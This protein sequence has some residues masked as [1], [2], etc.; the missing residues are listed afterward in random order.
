MSDI[1]IFPLHSQLALWIKN[2]N[3]FQQNG[4]RQMVMNWSL[5]GLKSDEHQKMFCNGKW[6]QYMY[7]RL[8]KPESTCENASNGHFYHWIP[9]SLQILLSAYQY[10]WNVE[11]KTA[12]Y[13]FKSWIS[14]SQCALRLSWS[15]LVHALQISC[16]LICIRVLWSNQ[17]TNRKI[18][19]WLW[20]QV[21]KQALLS[22]SISKSMA[23]WSLK[24]AHV[25]C[26]SFAIEINKR[27]ITE[28]AQKTR[29]KQ[30]K[31]INQ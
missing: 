23:F 29:T 25:I 20:L 31:R 10:E 12:A 4:R 18:S 27:H 9:F 8:Q 17:P 11:L 14:D 16:M 3:T 22:Q 1:Y 26:A 6:L 7:I 24:R 30:I 2:E 13:R 15:S 21:I 5:N 19:I 28:K